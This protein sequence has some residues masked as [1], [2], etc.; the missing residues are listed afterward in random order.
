MS[1]LKEYSSYDN[2]STFKIENVGECP[3]CK[4]TMETLTNIPTKRKTDIS[5]EWRWLLCGVGCDDSRCEGYPIKYNK[6]Y[7][8]CSNCQL[9]FCT[10]H[11]ENP[12]SEKKSDC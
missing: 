1:Q 11:S 3:K 9:D 7:Y 8:K 5:A 2:K 10:E 12:N 4:N 6:L